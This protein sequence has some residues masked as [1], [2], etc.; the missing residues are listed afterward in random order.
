MRHDLPVNMYLEVL[1]IAALHG[2]LRTYDQDAVLT[3]VKDISPDQQL[4]AAQYLIDKAMPSKA[5]V[6]ME[7]AP[8]LSY[9]Q[10]T[11]SP[12]QLTLD[13]LKHLAYDEPQ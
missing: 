7:A 11:S 12:E 10:V 13:Q 2:K 5:P 9:D 3:G 4:K 8:E 6:R 1:H